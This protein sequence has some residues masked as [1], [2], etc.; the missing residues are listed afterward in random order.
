MV[1]EW[2]QK[3]LTKDNSKD[4]K[5]LVGPFVMGT[6]VYSFGM[7]DTEEAAFCINFGMLIL[8]Q[9]RAKRMRWKKRACQMS[10][11]SQGQA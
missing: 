1:T 7:M 4:W 8:D 3:G 5:L 6:R 9:I 2:T 10:K 11:V